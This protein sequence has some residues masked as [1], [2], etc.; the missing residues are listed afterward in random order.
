MT[1]DD[2]AAR[3]RLHESAAKHFEQNGEPSMARRFRTLAAEYRADMERRPDTA[4]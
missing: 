2:L 1:I 4:E 3:I